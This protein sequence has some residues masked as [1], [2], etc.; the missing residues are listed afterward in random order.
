MGVHSR[1]GVGGQFGDG[2]RRADCSLRDHPIPTYLSWKSYSARN[3]VTKIN[4]NRSNLGR[5]RADIQHDLHG[6]LSHRRTK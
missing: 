1:S 6:K 2:V 5:I 3:D 4:E